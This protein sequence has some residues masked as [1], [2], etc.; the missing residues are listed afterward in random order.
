MKASKL[1]WI[2]FVLFTLKVSA[3]IDTAE[4]KTPFAGLDQSW[5]NGGDRRTTPP[6]LESKY[7]TGTVML[8][9]NY[10]YSFANPIDNT[11]VGSTA[12][13]RDNEVQLALGVIGGEFN[14]K[15]ARGKMLAQFGT[16]STVIPRDDYSPYRGQYHLP[17]VYRYLAEAYAGY[18]FDKW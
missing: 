11:V 4:S 15:N 8:D 14:Y 3:Q 2:V 12:L 10:T 17:D 7:F 18:H 5:Y 1:T 16:N 13:A 9:V 6:I